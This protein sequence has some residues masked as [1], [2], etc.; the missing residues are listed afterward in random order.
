MRVN[1]ASPKLFLACASGPRIRNA[2]LTVRRTGANPAEFLK[3]PL[4]DEETAKTNGKAVG[5]TPKH[6]DCSNR[7]FLMTSRRAAL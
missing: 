7:L 5:Q 1:K 6:S 2:I 4:S 3:W